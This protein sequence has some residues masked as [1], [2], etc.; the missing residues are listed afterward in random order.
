MNMTKPQKT[1]C[2]YTVGYD[3]DGAVRC[4]EE[5]KERLLPS[6][7]GKLKYFPLCDMHAAFVIDAE[8]K[9]L[10]LNGKYRP[11]EE[12]KEIVKRERVT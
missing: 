10:F 9:G 2:A 11:M 4:G 7:K 12:V 3:E 1:V 6:L 8:V 5:G